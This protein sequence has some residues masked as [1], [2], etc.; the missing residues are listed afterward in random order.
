[1]A[2]WNK[3]VRVASGGNNIFPPDY[4]GQPV[5]TATDAIG[6]DSISSLQRRM[7]SYAHGEGLARFSVAFVADAG[8]RVELVAERYIDGLGWTSDFTVDDAAPYAVQANQLNRLIDQFRGKYTT[9]QQTIWSILWHKR[10]SGEVFLVNDTEAGLGVVYTPYGFMSCQREKR[11]K[12]DGWKVQDRPNARIGQGA[13]WVPDSQMIRLWN[14]HP[15]YPQMPYSALWSGLKDLDRFKLLGQVID[16]SANSAMLNR[17]VVWF[18]GEAMDETIVVNG[19][20]MPKLAHDYYHSAHQTMTAADPSDVSAV[21]P[22][23]VHWDSDLGEPVH[24]KFGMPFD[25]A[26]MDMRTSTI[27]DYARSVDMPSVL[28]INGGAGGGSGASGGTGASNHWSDLL[29]DR[30]TFDLTIGRELDVVCHE[31][32]TRYFLR[33]QMKALILPDADV[34]RVG[35]DASRLIVNQD[36]TLFALDSLRVGL[37]SYD[38]CLKRLGFKPGEAATPADIQKLADLIT[39]ST[40]TLNMTRI[41]REQTSTDMNGQGTNSVLP[42]TAAAH[43]R[44]LAEM[45]ERAAAGGDAGDGIVWLDN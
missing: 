10:A 13:R 26:W 40:Q 2:L 33:P 37:I 34:W 38:A 44:S 42:M 28:I 24:I 27:E 17:G 7:H 1:M 9:T 6:G 20:T 32:L 12:E 41:R 21:A 15:D 36:R 19:K 14:P 35:Y 30:R 5:P 16:R 4:N 29:V 25:R 39:R 45:S 8:S 43:F 31:D 18:P 22:F 23:L 3:K 11:G